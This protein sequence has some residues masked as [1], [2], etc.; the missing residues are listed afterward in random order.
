MEKI[1][2]LDDHL[3]IGNS[4][5][6]DAFKSGTDVQL[7]DLDELFVETEQGE[8]NEMVAGYEEFL[9]GVVSKQTAIRMGCEDFNLD[10]FPS[11]HNARM[12]NEGFLTSIFEGFRKF[13]EAIIKYIR[14]AIDWVISLVRKIFGY[15]KT[16]R[17]VAAIEEKLPA[18]KE[19]F[20]KTILG[21]GLDPNVFNV[22]NFVGNLPPGETRAPQIRLFSD[23]LKTDEEAV[24]AL[25]TTFPEITEGMKVLTKLGNDAIFKSKKLERVVD[26]EFKKFRIA[27]NNGSIELN[28]ER[29]TVHINLDKAILELKVALDTQPMVDV[30]HKV[31]EKMYSVE[32][33]NEELGRGIKGIRDMVSKRAKERILKFPKGDH[34]KIMSRIS[35]LSSMYV[36][37]KDNDVNL[38]N[39]NWKALGNVINKS[40]AA[41]IEE[42]SNVLKSP[43]LL[44]LYQGVSNE[45]RA[46]SD[47]CALTARELMIIKEQITNVIT[48]Y[49]RINIYYMAGVIGDLETM[50]EVI[51]EA[52]SKGLN[53]LSDP[54]GLPPLD[55]VDTS[56]GQAKTRGEIFAAHA[57]VIYEADVSGIKTSVDNFRKQM[58]F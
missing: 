26:E 54:D 6:T 31:Y 50:K 55:F 58:G 21:F 47:L 7:V 36:A 49:A 8:I 32:V 25:A 3:Q 23:R 57:N 34:A 16:D 20:E 24:N 18:L 48:W 39:F 1:D 52:K 33:T 22:S 11:E 19:E 27:L 56:E 43:K 29:S 53:P 45:M 51:A 2:Y 35:E 4:N 37:A 9:K 46:Y 17:Q 15:E 12:G 42:I 14:K 13:I 44:A 40:D 41:K 10:P 5:P 38:K 28:P 30:V